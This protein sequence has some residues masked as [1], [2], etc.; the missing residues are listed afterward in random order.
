M[1]E[2]QRDRDRLAEEPI[3]IKSNA[4]DFARMIQLFRRL[5]DCLVFSHPFRIVID[6]DPEQPRVTT[7]IYEPT[8]VLQQYIQKVRGKVQD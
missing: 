7:K 8:E 5:T 2:K 4:K 6:F 3:T 1:L